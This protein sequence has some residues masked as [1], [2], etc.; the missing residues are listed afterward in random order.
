MPV[1]GIDSHKDTLAVAV[2]DN[3]GR[4]INLIEV[5]NTPAGFH[6]LV[7]WIGRHHPD[8][9]GIEGSGSH[10]RP[11][12]LALRD[13]GFDVVE[14]PPQMTA[15]TR[16][17]QRS[18]A[19]T[20][21]IDAV[22]IARIALRENDLPP[23]RTNGAIEDMRVLV[24][25]RREL[26]AERNRIA[27]RLHSDLEQLHLGYQQ[28][29]GR[30]TTERN[31]DRARR[32]LTGN[33][34]TRARIARQRVTRLRQLTRQIDELA[35]EITGHSRRLD[36]G[37]TTIPGIADLSAAELIAEIGDVGR[38]RTRAQFAM[39]NGTAPIPASSGRTD[40]HRLNRG[41]NR[42]LNRIIHFVALTQ[43]SRHPEGRAYY[44]RK[45][46]EG[47][48]RKEAMRCLKRRISDRIYRTLRDHTTRTQLT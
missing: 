34:Q 38:Y 26:L 21:A 17:Q 27:N 8:R 28:R 43:I 10:G 31:L 25:Y 9:V 18:G 1:A 45:Q 37:L 42:Q 47:K 30:L 7:G 16:R 23:V 44:Q 4:R 22:V 46:A 40:R 24:H 19:K 14:V 2:V 13:A 15:A 39:A 6:H 12:A 29:I 5:E 41:G 11:A 20:D 48:T 3:Q 32:L 35:T 36:T 33:Q